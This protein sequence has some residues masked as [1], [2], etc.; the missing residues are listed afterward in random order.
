MID[1]AGIISPLPS[2]TASIRVGS[3]GFDGFPDNV[4][5]LP[6]VLEPLPAPSFSRAGVVGAQPL[7]YDVPLQIE[8]EADYATSLTL[9]Y[10]DGI[11]KYT[12]T[13]SANGLP[14]SGTWILQN[15]TVDAQVTLTASNVHNGG[16]PQGVPVE[17]VPSPTPALSVE[18]SPAAWDFGAGAVEMT[19]TLTPEPARL[20]TALTVDGPDGVVSLMGRTT[21]A[22]LQTSAVPLV[23]TATFGTGVG[24][25]AHDIPVSP[26]VP[27][28]ASYVVGTKWTTGDF[29]DG[30][31]AFVYTFID[32]KNGTINDFLGLTQFTYTADANTVAVTIPTFDPFLFHWDGNQLVTVAQNPMFV[33]TRA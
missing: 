22:V 4:T 28:L 9:E 3:S 19:Y 13:S 18:F 21:Y 5:N 31:G 1:L 14:L 27:S 32:E 24:L 2:G 15:T 29:G 33:L 12:F 11:S 20:L 17:V 26:V 7:G 8:W 10:D 16:T 25:H 30:V 23:F 6:V